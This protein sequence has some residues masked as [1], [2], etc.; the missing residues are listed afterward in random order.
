MLLETL[1]LQYRQPEQ[2]RAMAYLAAPDLYPGLPKRRSL[3]VLRLLRIADP[4]SVWALSKSG[5]TYWVRRIEWVWGEIVGST[6][7][8]FAAETELDS[9]TVEDLIGE[10][11]EM[12]VP[13]MPTP[14]CYLI[15]G[16]VSYAIRVGDYSLSTEYS[17]THDPPQAWVP[18][19]SWYERMHAVFEA[20]LP[21]AASPYPPSEPDEAT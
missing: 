15:S 19:A 6:T 10:F 12:A 20:A 21:E 7:G 9:A 11:A 18:L 3:E 8:V 4:M 5:E 16:G 2:A 13:T 17:W 14:E 1:M